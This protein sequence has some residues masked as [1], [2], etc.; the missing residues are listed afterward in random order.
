MNLKKKYNQVKNK[1][2]TGIF[3]YNVGLFIGGLGV[4]FILDLLW[5]FIAPTWGL[6]I[7]TYPKFLATLFIIHML[8]HFLGLKEVNRSA[9]PNIV[10]SDSLGEHPNGKQ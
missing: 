3:W 7:L 6:P 10:L 1:Q 2:S 4:A 8:M 9:H 5:N